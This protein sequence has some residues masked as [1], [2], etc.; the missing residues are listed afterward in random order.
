MTKEEIQKRVIEQ[1][2]NTLVPNT[3]SDIVPE[4]NMVNDLGAD[5]L[6]LVEVVLNIEKEFS[7]NIPDEIMD[8]FTTVADIINYL[9]TKLNAA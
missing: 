5:S 9:D 6:D 3:L 1:V 7:I 8:T 4:T 2:Y